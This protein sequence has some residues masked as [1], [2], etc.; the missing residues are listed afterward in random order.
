MALSDAPER[1]TGSS[2][3]WR[4]RNVLVLGLVSLLTD[5]ASDMVLPLLPAFLGVLGAGALVLG[6]MEGAAEGV[7]SLL[8]VAAGRASDRRGTYRPFV[9]VGYTLSSFA[10]PLVALAASPWHVLAVRLTDR[11]GKGVRSSPRDAI[12]AG[13]VPP[14][15]LG[16]AF[17]LHRAMDHAG[18]VIGPL[19]AFAF[20]RYVSDDLRLLFGLSVIP[21]LLVVGLVWFAVREPEAPPT[22]RVA[23]PRASIH[24]DDRRRLLAILLPVTLFSLGNA[25]DLFLLMKASQTNSP[26]ESLPLLWVGL[27][28]VKM[29]ASLPAG[30]LA[31]RVGRRRVV[32]LGWVVYALVYL[33]FAVVES[34]EAVWA[35]FVVYGLYHGLTEGVEKALVAEVAPAHARGTAFGWYHGA[36]G[37]AALLASGVFGMVWQLAGSSAAF[38]MGATLAGL[39]VVALAVADRTVSSAHR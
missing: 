30:Q 17:G 26:L 21:G 23:A 4:T 20:L 19:I 29:V 18:A 11:T 13:S 34:R 16:A 38:V 37:I 35:L 12:L 22:P 10:R 27:H 7:A 9:R 28:V 5:A 24:G 1:P 36:M 33:G 25:S 39:A 6:W 8:K 2:S 32:A 31:D 3:V 15:R 14:E